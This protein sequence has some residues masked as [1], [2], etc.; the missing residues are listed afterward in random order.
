METTKIVK[1]QNRKLYNKDT[2]HYLNLTDI[3]NL[4]F[5]GKN[6]TVIENKTKEDITAITFSLCLSEILKRSRSAP[7]GRLETL[8][9]EALAHEELTKGGLNGNTP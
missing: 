4:I 1:Y 3:G 8:I 2:S 5:E 9:K 6:V 7:I